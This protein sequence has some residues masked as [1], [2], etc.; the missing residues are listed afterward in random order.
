ME[1]ASN[2]TRHVPGLP[3]RS[4][5]YARIHAKRQH[6]DKGADYAPPYFSLLFPTEL[7]RQIR[8]RDICVLGRI[9]PAW[10]DGRSLSSLITG[11]IRTYKPSWTIP[12]LM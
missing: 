2:A 12:R 4:F 8:G 1:W 10:K 11:S 5:C 6:R 3:W 7:R 9:L